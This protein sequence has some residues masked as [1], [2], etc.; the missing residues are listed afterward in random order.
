[1]PHKNKKNTLD[2]IIQMAWSDKV[3]FEDIQKKTKL[4]EKNIIQIMR[5]ELNNKSYI[6]WRKRVKGRKSKHRKLNEF[7]D[8]D[9][10]LL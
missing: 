1:M 6:L 9:N 3:S 4:S 5:K 7:R 2:N 10:S 8:N